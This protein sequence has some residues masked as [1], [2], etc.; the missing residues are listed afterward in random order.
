MLR[1]LMNAVPYAKA[2][3]MNEVSRTYKILEDRLNQAEW[4]AGDEYT[5]AD[6]ALWG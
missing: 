4:L 3:Y 2:R 5:I 6:M 1:A